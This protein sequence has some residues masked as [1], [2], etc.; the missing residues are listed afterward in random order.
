MQDSFAELKA[1]VQEMQSVLKRGDDAAVHAK[2]QSH[3]RLAK[4]AQK[5]F[6]KINSKVASDIEACRVVK[7]LA[8]ERSLLLCL[9]PHC[10][11]C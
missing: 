10:S 11:S 9:N 1:T 8:E 2:V 6:K 5:Q 7:L 4:K 3:A